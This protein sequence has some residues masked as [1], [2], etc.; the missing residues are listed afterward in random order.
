MKRPYLIAV[1][2]I[3][4]C[5]KGTQIKKLREWLSQKTKSE[6]G[7]WYEPNDESSPI[8]KTIRAVL[9]KEFSVSDPFEFQRMY[10]VDRAQNIFS[11]LL[12]NKEKHD[13]K[14]VDRFALSTIAYGMLTGRPADDFIK[15]HYDVLGPSMVWPDLTII[16]DVS[17]DTAIDRINKRLK[18]DKRAKETFEKKKF[19]ENIRQ[20]YLS[21]AN[22]KDVGTI[23]VVNGERPPE[24]VFEDVKKAVAKH[25]GI[26]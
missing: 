15:L 3:D 2:G 26:N 16:I 24:E 9:S 8:A 23:A 12:H 18:E 17:A 10:V 7:G 13:Y 22:R 5:G 6:V 21:L 20:N 19:L 14:V 1:E 4:G 25:F 11:L